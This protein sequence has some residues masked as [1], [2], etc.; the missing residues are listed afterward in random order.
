MESPALWRLVQRFARRFHVCDEANLKQIDSFIL[1]ALR[2]QFYGPPGTFEDL[3]EQAFDLRID[4]GDGRRYNVRGFIDRAFKVTDKRGKWL[5]IKDF[6][7][8]KDYFKGDKAAFNIQSQIYQLAAR[9]LFPDFKR[10][11]FFF[12]FLKFGKRPRQEMESLTDS[13]L[14]G[15]ETMLTDLQQAM[16]SF[17]EES[18]TSNLA[19]DSPSHAW[20][21]GRVGVKPDGSPAFICSARLPMDYWVELDGAG[22]IVTSAFTEKEL[23]PKVGNR[24]EKRSYPGCPRHFD[25]K[26]GKRRNFQ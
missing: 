18:V 6:K 5:S 23:K 4:R 8:S 17:N 14:D 21:C 7:T 19:A 13:Q 1:V 16:E 11:D 25:P 26:T 22:G 15:F 9:E 24:V 12:A 20:L 10:R 2:D 3:T